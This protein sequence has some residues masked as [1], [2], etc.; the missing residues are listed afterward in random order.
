MLAVTE[1][2]R[3]DIIDIM[4]LGNFLMICGAEF[5]FSISPAEAPIVKKAFSSFRSD[6]PTVRQNKKVKE[7]HS[8]CC[9]SDLTEGHQGPDGRAPKRRRTTQLHANNGL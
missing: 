3:A 7:F 1:D 5:A 9:W 6:N 2:L 4:Y 8:F